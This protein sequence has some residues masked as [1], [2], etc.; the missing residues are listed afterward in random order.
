[1]IKNIPSEFGVYWRRKRGMQM[2]LEECWAKWE[3]YWN[4][5]QNGGSSLN[6]GDQ[7]VLGR[8]GDQGA[9]TVENC[10]VITHRENTL[11]RDHSKCRDRLLGRV[12]NPQ[13]GRTVR[14]GRHHGARI[15]SPGGEYEN[16]SKAATQLGLHRTSVWHR[17]QSPLWPDWGWIE[18]S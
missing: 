12:M 18:E 3:L 15:R 17:V 7:Y 2:T 10:R 5:R 6:A 11:E 16:C 14:P 9:Y 4:L 1:M 8:L 13:G